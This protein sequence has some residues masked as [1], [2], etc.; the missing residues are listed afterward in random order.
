L[1]VVVFV[2]VALGIPI[3]HSP[4]HPLRHLIRFPASTLPPLLL[5]ILPTFFLLLFKMPAPSNGTFV[6]DKS[7][8]VLALATAA[9][10]LY[11]HRFAVRTSVP[12]T[13]FGANPETGAAPTFVSVTRTPNELSIVAPKGWTAENGM[14]QPTAEHC[15]GPWTAIRVR[16][17]LEHGEHWDLCDVGGEERGWGRCAPS[18]ASFAS[19]SGATPGVDMSAGRETDSRTH[20]QSLTADMVGV[21]NEIATSLK[22]AGISIFALSTW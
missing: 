3:D 20:L 11:V 22:N 5:V 2:V 7:N 9:D 18:P 21:L 4:S 15:G 12:A 10:N 6:L 13:L 17:P 14:A 8:P 1:I 16:G 19:P